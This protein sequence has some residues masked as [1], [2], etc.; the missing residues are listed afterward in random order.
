MWELGLEKSSLSCCVLW[1]TA[2]YPTGNRTEGSPMLPSNPFPV[3]GGGILR[4]PRV[5]VVPL[6]QV[7]DLG[8]GSFDL[9]GPSYF[10]VASRFF[11]QIPNSPCRIG[12]TR[13]SGTLKILVSPTQSTN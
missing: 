8:W 2:E 13:V 3:C 4:S 12:Q 6:G 7:V 10:P 11:C 1:A 9:G 5:Q